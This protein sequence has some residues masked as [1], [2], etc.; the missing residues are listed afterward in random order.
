M[1]VLLDLFLGDPSWIM[2]HKMEIGFEKYG[3]QDFTT[4]SSWKCK[5]SKMLALNFHEKVWRLDISCKCKWIPCL[6][7]YIN[8]FQNTHPGPGPDGQC[9]GYLVLVVV[10]KWTEN[11]TPQ[12]MI[13]DQKLHFRK[14]YY[15]PQFGNI[16]CRAVLKII[17]PQNPFSQKSIF[18]QILFNKTEI[19][20]FSHY[21]RVT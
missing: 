2:S 20:L 10:Q 6:I 4:K 3:G 15:C 5:Y 1:L 18:T 9:E 19:C 7:K 21:P 17:F 12:S 14:K 16:H 13:L 11:V 8:V